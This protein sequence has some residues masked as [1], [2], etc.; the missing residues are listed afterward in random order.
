MT[1]YNDKNIGYHDGYPLFLGPD[2]GLHDTINRQYPVLE[3]L[4]Q[5]QLAQLWNEFEVDLTQDVMDMKKLPPGTVDLMTKTVSW[6]WAADSIAGRSIADLLGPYIS[7]SELEGLANLWSFFETIHARTYSHIV[8]QTYVNPQAALEETMANQQVLL[9][10][11]PILAA[12]DEVE[13]LPKD[14]SLAQKQDAIIKAFVALFALEAIAFM[15]SFAVTF[16]IGERGFFQ[17]IV[18]LVKLV[19]RDEKLHTQMDYSILA[20]LIKDPKWIAAIKRN[21]AAIQE[22][23]DTV[24]ENEMGW[25]E[26]V[27]SEG[28]QVVGLTEP[29]LKEYVRFM[30]APVYKALGASISFTIPKHN[31]LPYMDK[32]L[33]G[34]KVQSAAQEIQLSSYNVGALVDDTADMDF[35]DL[36]M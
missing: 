22:I 24:V 25:T 12:F 14:A 34:S 28:R 4:Y 31:P 36:D 6:Q 20:I 33:N 30:A 10:T 21:E 11:G 1:R 19:A 18:Q 15:A 23:L 9:R 5:K 8:K 35:D 32:Y 17:G 16:A 13:A 2:L 27:F 3:E 26:Y 7:N 29:M